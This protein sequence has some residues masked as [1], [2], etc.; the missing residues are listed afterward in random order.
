MRL[1]TSPTPDL[2][3]ESLVMSMS[4]IVHNFR[5]QQHQKISVKLL[6]AGKA[7]D[8]ARLLKLK[9][10]RYGN[11]QRGLVDDSHLL[12]CT[13]LASQP[14]LRLRAKRIQ[15]FCLWS[16]R[17]GVCFY[18]TCRSD[19]IIGSIVLLISWFDISPI[20]TFA[21]IHLRLMPLYMFHS[22]CCKKSAIRQVRSR[23]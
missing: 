11:S 4:T 1:S 5:L 10:H 20:I 6:Q 3:S 23:V 19:S 8:S 18:R 16:C 9:L 12:A 14:A 15:C 2:A 17:A 21:Q 13:R 7:A 22:P